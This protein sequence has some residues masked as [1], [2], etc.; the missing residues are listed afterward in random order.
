MP[1]K[2]SRIHLTI[3]DK[4]Q[5]T[6]SLREMKCL[7]VTPNWQDFITIQCKGDDC[8]ANLVM[9]SEDAR[10]MAKTILMALLKQEQDTEKYEQLYGP[11]A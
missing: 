7:A 5:V 3:D 8:N 4:T 9:D 1:D 2:H 11:T 6:L 10:G